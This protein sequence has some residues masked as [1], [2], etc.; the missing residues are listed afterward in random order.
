MYLPYIALTQDEKMNR[1]V[2]DRERWFNTVIGDKVCSETEVTERL[3][4][5][6]LLPTQLVEDLSY[7]LSV[8]KIKSF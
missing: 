1:V 2:M 5:R 4:E 8:V 7:D 3:A 6:I